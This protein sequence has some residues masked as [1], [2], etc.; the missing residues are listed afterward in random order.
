MVGV[1]QL[2]VALQ[3]YISVPQ[4]GK[5]LGVTTER[6][7]QLVRAGEVQAVH[8]PLGWL[9]EPASAAELVAR[10]AA[11]RGAQQAGAGRSA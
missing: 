4:L 10:R 1:E 11:A 2:A 6:A 9:V 8:C 3:D 5:R 7:R